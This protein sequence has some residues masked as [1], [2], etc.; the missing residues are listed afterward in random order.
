MIMTA[1]TAPTTDL[2][3]LEEATARL[4]TAV[5]A[6]D[7]AAVGEPSA[8]RGWTRGHV[9]AHLSR[10]ADALVNVL[11]GRPMYPS[12]EA[13]NDDIERDAARPAATHREDLR[14]SS[15]RLHAAATEL[16]DEQWGTVVTLRNGVTDVA[17]SIPLRRWIEVELHH[18]DLSLGLSV[19]EL[20][21]VFLDRA[22]DYLTAR[23]AGHPDVRS[24][25]LRAEDGRR[26]RTGA[27]PEESVG[28]GAVVVVGTP[29]ALVGWLSGRTTGSGLS[30]TGGE[31]LPVLP[32]L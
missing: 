15:A 3:A 28:G 2:T 16:T 21:G 12:D 24:L 10:N 29:A 18:L 30:I 4:L 23:F 13:R 6:L 25:E 27:A 26:W 17:A 31:S 20:P 14:D 22:L 7:D 32:P 8:L 11:A 9:L 19:A 1:P 5:D